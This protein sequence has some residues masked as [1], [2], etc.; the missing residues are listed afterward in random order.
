M[1]ENQIFYDTQKMFTKASRYQFDR[2]RKGWSWE[3]FVGSPGG[4]KIFFLEKN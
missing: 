2:S 1:L 3:G 4:E